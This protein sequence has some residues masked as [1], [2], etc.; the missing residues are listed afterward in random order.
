[1]GRPKMVIY[2]LWKFIFVRELE[3]KGMA[4]IC[5]IT[6]KWW[7]SQWACN[8]SLWRG[9]N[10]RN[11][12]RN[13]NL[14]SKCFNPSKYT[15]GLSFQSQ[16]FCLQKTLYVLPESVTFK[17]HHLFCINETQRRNPQHRWSDFWSFSAE[18]LLNRPKHGQTVI[19]PYIVVYRWLTHKPI[20]GNLLNNLYDNG[21]KKNLSV[22]LGLEVEKCLK[23]LLKPTHCGYRTLT[24]T[25][26]A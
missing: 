18:T 7:S 6:W 25:V 16:R 15:V 14:I 21:I 13:S 5:F 11:A 12:H 19:C 3:E 20:C 1:M 22:F 8:K 17:L 9:K 26:W 23:R 10:N 24:I 4:M 2:C